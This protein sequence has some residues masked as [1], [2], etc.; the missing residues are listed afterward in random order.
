L[1]ES[2]DNIKQSNVQAKG[3]GTLRQIKTF[4]FIFATLLLDPILSSILKISAFL[5]SSDINLLTAVEINES[6]KRLLVSMKNT[7]ENFTDIYHKT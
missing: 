5:Q 2:I 6:L 1:K 3:N 7:E 4:E